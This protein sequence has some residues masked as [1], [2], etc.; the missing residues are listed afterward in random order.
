VDVE[1]FDLSACGGSH[2]AR[3]GEIGIIAVQ[4]WERFKGGQRLEF[5]CGGRVL[6]RFRDLRD[7]TTG[8]V[9]LLS[10][11]PEE[12]P[13][14]IE[15]LQAATREHSRALLVLERELA[16]YRGAELATIAEPVGSV[17]LVLRSIDAD[18]ASLKLLASAATAHPGCL[19]VLVSRAQ[20]IVLVV[21][22]SK[23]VSTACDE[24]VKSLV[25]QFGGR[26]GG[27]PDMAQA[28]GLTGPA[29]AILS[30][31]RRQIL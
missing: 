2:V 29:D 16:R 9:R 19:V 30:Q 20:P 17:R 12:V 14:A 23:D 13:T 22:R 28:G 31:A 3:T 26:G 5:L 7:A 25:Q 27:K 4:G 1:Q 18:A 10:V 21:A 11:L 15:H 8:A 24:I 6:S